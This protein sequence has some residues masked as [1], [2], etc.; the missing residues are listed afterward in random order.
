MLMRPLS[1]ICRPGRRLYTAHVPRLEP[2]AIARSLNAH[3]EV[4]ETLVQELTP[5]ARRE[6]AI[7]LMG[8]NQ[9]KAFRQAD[10]DGDG[11]LSEQYVVLSRLHT[12]WGPRWVSMGRTAFRLEAHLN[13]FF[14]TLL[15]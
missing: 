10:M 15:L 7:A 11:V 1:R 2:R 6:L 3:S 14:N 12:R 9:A 8:G 13:W 4:T 5:E